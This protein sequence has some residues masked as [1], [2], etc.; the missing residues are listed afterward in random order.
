M[1]IDVLVLSQCVC[2]VWCDWS[3]SD[4]RADAHE[5][6]KRSPAL[7][8]RFAHCLQQLPA[9]QPVPESGEASEEGAGSHADTEAHHEAHLDLVKAAWAMARCVGA[10]GRGRHSPDSL[11]L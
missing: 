9:S 5:D 3:T 8:H 4:A 1:G 10:R 2:C 6:A 7:H 11:V